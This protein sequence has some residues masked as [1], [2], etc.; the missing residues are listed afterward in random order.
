MK[1]KYEG[2]RGRRL[3]EL[4]RNIEQGLRVLATLKERREQ[5]QR[6]IRVT[7]ET[8]RCDGFPGF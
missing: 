6:Q 4:D 5:L 1:L 8:N 3:R 2:E 7:K